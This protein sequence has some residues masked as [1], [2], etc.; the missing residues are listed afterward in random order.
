MR[1][2]IN[3]ENN[4]LLT[5][6]IWNI[7]GKRGVKN[8]LLEA[9]KSFYSETRNYVRMHNQNLLGRTKSMT[10]RIIES[11]ALHSYQELNN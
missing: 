10:G 5:D 6:Q 4:R 7:L 11:E 9:I 8:E 1:D 2:D 3:T